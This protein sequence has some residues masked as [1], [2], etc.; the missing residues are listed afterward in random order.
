VL[1]VLCAYLG[2]LARL[3]ERLASDVTVVIDERDQ[4]LLDEQQEGDEA[5]STLLPVTAEKVQVSKRVCLLLVLLRV[6]SE[7]DSRYG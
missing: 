2:Q 5:D 7:V 1:Q 3:R 6:H 4:V